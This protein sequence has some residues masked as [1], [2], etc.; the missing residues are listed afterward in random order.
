MA[1]PAPSPTT[2]AI[3]ITFFSPTTSF[4]TVAGFNS[5]KKSEFQFLGAS[6][7][8][9]CYFHLRPGFPI[10]LLLPFFSDTHQH[11]TPFGNTGDDQLY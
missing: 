3:L 9:G 11:G 10:H 1:P 2:F 8:T 4:Y 6:Q 7:L 5:W